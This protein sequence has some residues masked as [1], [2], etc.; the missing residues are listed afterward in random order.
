M[1]G[2]GGGFGVLCGDNDLDGCLA[3]ITD[4]TKY[5]SG[6]PPQTGF[7][8]HD[9][10]GGTYTNVLT[11]GGSDLIIGR[12]DVDDAGTDTVNIWIN[13][14]D[15][16]DL[17]AA[18]LVVVANLVGSAG[19]TSVSFE[20]VRRTSAS[21]SALDHV[22]VSD[23]ST[24]QLFVTGNPID[25]VFKLA[26]GSPD[27]DLDFGTT[28]TT[29]ANLSRTLIYEVESTSGTATVTVDDLVLTDDPAA[30]GAFTLGTVTPSVPVTL[31]DGDTIEIEVIA[32]ASSGSFNGSLLIDTTAAGGNVDADDYDTTLA[33]QSTFLAD[34]E[35][36]NPNPYM[37]A[38]VG[39]EWGGGSTRVVP[40]IAPGSIG[41]AR[42]KGIGDPAGDSSNSLYQATSIRDGL[43]NWAFTSYFT[44]IDVTNWPGYT[45]ELAPSGDFTDRTFQW[46]LLSTDADPVNPNLGDLQA[47]NTIINLAY[48]PDGNADGGDADFYV[49]DGVAGEWVATGI[50]AIAGSV[51]NDTD[52]DPS[53]GFGDG[54]LDPSIDPLDVVNTY[55]LTVSGTGFGSGGTATYD[56]T[57][58]KVSGPDSF[59]SGSATGLS[60][61][62]GSNP[63][64]NA[65][66]SYAFTTSDTSTSSN[67][68]AGYTTSFWVDD[69]CYL[70]GSVPDSALVIL[71]QP[72]TMSAF[73]PDTGDSTSFRVRNDGASSGLTIDPLVFSSPGFSA[74]TPPVLA[75]G[76]FADL[77]I[78]FDSLT[79]GSAAE[80]IVTLTSDATL[81]SA[82]AIAVSASATSFSSLLPNFDFE[83]PG[84]DPPATPT[85][86]RSGMKRRTS[87]ADAGD[88]TLARDVPGLIAGSATA[89]LLDKTANSATISNQFGIAVTDFVAELHFAIKDTTNRQLSPIIRN[90]TGA[91]R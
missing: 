26:A 54:L 71:T 90:E 15:V 62:H 1:G 18:D 21:T 67:A 51:D 79:G 30:P 25:P 88:P 63:S 24:G 3:V 20:F 23:A 32:N 66:A 70:N 45:G 29:A 14:A 59:T 9:A 85:P 37:D 19:I 48:L 36:L 6:A 10:G 80:E 50:G 8:F 82:P 12:V 40:G 68:G 86:S 55:Q 52:G 53:N 58:T 11:I 64:A 35:K 47:A 16:L 89:C 61:Y 91:G 44:P 41:M 43:E 81:A 72:G 4:T 56:I 31:N 74:S 83:A 7:T 38:N 69:T 42:V 87:V 13:P 75:P 46:A 78:S 2:A 17:G 28:Y 60:T 22:R 76:E 73:E 27:S 77:S 49:Y 5:I 65:P 57:V 33:I 84:T 34:G 39:P